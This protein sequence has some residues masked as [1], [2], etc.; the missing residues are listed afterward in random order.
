M[1]VERRTLILG[2]ALLVVVA[3]WWWSSG[4][5]A[6]PA[7]V[8]TQRTAAANAQQTAAAGQTPI[9]VR[10]EA[11]SAERAAP[12]GTGRNPFEFRARPAP[13]PPPKPSGEV[14]GVAPPPVPAGPPPPPPITLKFIGLVEGASGLRIAV[15][16]DGRSSPIYAQQGKVI[17]GQYRVVTIGVESIE[18]EHIDGRGRQTIRLT[19]Q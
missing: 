3:V 14:A 10:I 4:G 5:S 16:S 1:R 8:T 7:A 19:G 2:G 18:L 9:D 13:P 11:L 12:A 17:L 15:L 6:T